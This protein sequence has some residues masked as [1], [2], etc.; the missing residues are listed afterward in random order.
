MRRIPVRLIVR[1]VTVVDAQRV[2]CRECGLRFAM[3]ARNALTWRT[4]GENPVC[5]RCRFPPF[6]PSEAERARMRR[7][8]LARYSLDE[9]LELGDLL[10]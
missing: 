4:R 3:S 9:L 6:E 2:V 10:G 1:G 7:W 5:E 8:W